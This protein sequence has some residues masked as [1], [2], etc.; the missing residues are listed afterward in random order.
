MAIDGSAGT[1]MYRF[2][3]DFG[4]LEFLKY[5][6]TNLAYYIRHAGRAA[7]IGVG[8]GRDILSAHLFRIPGFNRRRA[9]PDFHRYAV[10]GVSAI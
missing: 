7:V 1:A 9:K 6:V 10:T 5:D 3:G 4:K 2:D 8:G